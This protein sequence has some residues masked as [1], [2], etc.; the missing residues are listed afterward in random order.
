MA[1]MFAALAAAGLLASAAAAQQ[2]PESPAPSYAL[3]Q[4]SVSSAK[5]TPAQFRKHTEAIRSCE[6]AVTLA[7]EIGADVVRNARVTPDR[8]PQQLRPVMKDLPLG[9]ATQVFSGSGST[10]RVLVLCARG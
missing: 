4:L 1:R 8:L 2:A 6:E 10:L 7:G 5:I 3:V 9:H